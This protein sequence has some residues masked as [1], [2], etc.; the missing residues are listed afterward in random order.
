MP[1]PTSVSIA[2]RKHVPGVDKGVSTMLTAASWILQRLPG[3]VL[4][5]Q[6]GELIRTLSQSQA[7]SVEVTCSGTPTV[8][9]RDG[10]RLLVEIPAKAQPAGGGS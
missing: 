4:E 3:Q 9:V 6:R 10:S 2:G 7:L 5:E 1:V 8:R